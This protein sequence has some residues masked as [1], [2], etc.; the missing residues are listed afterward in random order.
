[1]LLRVERHRGRIGNGPVEV[2]PLP[3]TAGPGKSTV[4]ALRSTG[5]PVSCGGN[6]HA[7][8]GS[9]RGGRI[10]TQAMRALICDPFRPYPDRTA[11]GT[12]R[13]E[14]RS[15]RASGFRGAVPLGAGPALHRQ[16][17]CCV[18]SSDPKGPTRTLWQGS[19]L[20]LVPWYGLSSGVRAF[21]KV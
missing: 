5:R 8:D 17:T 18:R 7:S 3:P 6:R 13:P 21:P 19:S 12:K 9:G 2:C 14:T 16:L 10:P 11:K 20:E 15:P 4:E 1:M